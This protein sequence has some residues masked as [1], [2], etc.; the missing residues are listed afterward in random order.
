MA[1]NTVPL[2]TFRLEDETWQQFKNWCDANH[3]NASKELKRHIDS[4]INPDSNLDLSRP[5]KLASIDNQQ[6]ESIQSIQA[7]TDKLYTEMEVIKRSS[8]EKSRLL[9]DKLNE[10]KETL[11][12][13]HGSRVENES[14]SKIE[15]LEEQVKSLQDSVLTV[16]TSNDNLTERLNVL[17]KKL[18]TQAVPKKTLL[19]TNEVKPKTPIEDL[20]LPE[21]DLM[22]LE[23]DGYDV[24]KPLGIKDALDIA[25]MTETTFCRYRNNGR[26]PEKGIDFIRSVGSNGKPTYTY[27]RKKI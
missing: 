3:T 22:R 12:A 15:F 16:N 9:E 19:R 4:L 8:E 18:E 13:S 5:N 20:I 26:L 6:Q 17:E 2:R 21:V 25:L 1:T 27:F 23:I 14:Q 7:S 24:D 11:A 10:L